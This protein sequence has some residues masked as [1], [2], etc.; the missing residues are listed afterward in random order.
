[1]ASQEI[2]AEAD[3]ENGRCALCG[4]PSPPAEPVWPG[5]VRCPVCG[6]LYTHPRPTPAAMP[7]Y[8]ESDYYSYQFHGVR[9]RS[10][11]LKIALWRALG[12][13]P[14]RPR[15]SR[16]PALARWARAL[17]TSQHGVAATWTLAAPCAEARFL[18]VGCGAGERLELARDL[19]WE[20]WGV[21]LGE[22]AVRDAARR[23]HR[24]AV[25]SAEALPFGDAIFD[26]LNLSHVLEHLYEPLEAL[27]ECSRLL[28]PEGVVQITVPNCAGWG[29]RRYGPHWR[30]WDLPRHLYHFTVATLTALAERAGLRVAV[31]RTLTDEWVLQE[32]RR[33]AGEKVHGS[34]RPTYASRLRAR[35]GDGE[36]LD[37]WCMPQTE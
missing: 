28:R 21:D 1:M 18:D 7:R 23:G 10:H 33:A 8:Y 20:T 22:A 29:A 6:L 19:G 37:V 2:G 24:T 9:P 31:T 14:P 4:D 3:V 5:L 34:L 30:A 25:A 12:M 32:S 26:Y 16:P 36:N 27:R 35:R 17:L 11:R 13:L 15:S